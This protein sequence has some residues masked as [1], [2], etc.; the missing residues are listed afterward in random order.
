M[1][2]GHLGVC[3]FLMPLVNQQNYLS[4]SSRNT[5]LHISSLIG[6]FDAC[7]YLLQSGAEVNARNDQGMTPLFQ[8]IIMGWLD[9]TKELIDGGATISEQD[10]F[11]RTP[12]HWAIVSYSNESIQLLLDHPD[13]MIYIPDFCGREPIH[14]AASSGNDELIKIFIQMGC[15]PSCT[16]NNGL[17][18]LHLACA[19]G[20]ISCCKILL[21]NDVPFNALDFSENVFKMR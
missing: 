11:G 7:I 13:C 21:D 6:H 15:D 3:K 18:P 4:D 16:E 20:S 5:P 10:N 19:S 14:E 12:L 17:T 2:L 8:S 9:I 1:K